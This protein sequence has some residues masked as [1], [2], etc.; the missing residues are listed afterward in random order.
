MSDEMNSAGSKRR[1]IVNKDF[2][3]A[4]VCL[5]VS[6]TY[7]I[8][9]R[10]YPNLSPDYLEVS[11]AFFP[12]I[13]A[14]AMIVCSVCMLIK[15]IVNPKH[16]EPMTSTEK[17]GYLRGLLTILVCFVYVLIFEPLGYILSSML[18]V[19]T[20]MIIF[21]NRRWPVVIAI[22][23]VFPIVLYVAFRY[24]LLIRLPAGIL[25]FLN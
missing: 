14:A 6:V 1:L 9:A 10:T 8:C 5:A 15:A 20:L 21:G 22:T 12:T 16:Y 7:M 24:G 11:A 17:R 13:V 25:T 18:A 2:L 19:F 23:V 3:T 4:L